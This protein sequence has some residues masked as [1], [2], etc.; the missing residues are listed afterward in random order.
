MAQV[1]SEAAFEPIEGD[2]KKH[3][4]LFK[5]ANREEASQLQLLTASGKP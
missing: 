5:K 2:N 4:S 1:I 3:C